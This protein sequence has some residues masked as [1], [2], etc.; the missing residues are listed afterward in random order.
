MKENFQWKHISPGRDNNVQCTNN[1][2]KPAIKN[3][4][5]P[6]DSKEIG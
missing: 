2:K 5:N 1:T 6:I 3:H 4:Q